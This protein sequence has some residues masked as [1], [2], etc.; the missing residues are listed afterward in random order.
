MTFFQRA[1]QVISAYRSRTPSN[2]ASPDRLSLPSSSAEQRGTSRVSSG[3]RESRTASANYRVYDDSLPRHTQP[4]TPAQLPEA[5]HQSRFHPSLTAPA[6]RAVSRINPD[7]RLHHYPQPTRR[8]LSF[9]TPSRRTSGRTNSPTG[10][11]GRGFEGLYGGRENG[12]EEQNWTEGVRF[13]N[14]GVRLWA[15]RDA[16]NDGRSLRDTPEPEEWRVGRR[17]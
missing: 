2:N 8:Q 16:R 14:A 3:Q 11:H 17:E 1:A 5:R 9:A 4:Q 6:A 15:L 13:N 12:D 7:A 10:L